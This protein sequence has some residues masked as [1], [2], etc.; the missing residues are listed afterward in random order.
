MFFANMKS[1]HTAYCSGSTISGRV[2][3]AQF[4]YYRSDATNRASKDDGMGARDG[5]STGGGLIYERRRFVPFIAASVGGR[6]PCCFPF[7]TT[8]AP[9]GHSPN[10]RMTRNSILHAYMLKT[11]YE[12]PRLISHQLNPSP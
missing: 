1:P 5:P 9:A 12:C 3:R 8:L 7:L 4:S 6:R 10:T 2:Q 11:G